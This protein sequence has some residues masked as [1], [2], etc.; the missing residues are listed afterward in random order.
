MQNKANSLEDY[1]HQ[2]PKERQIVIKKIR[3]NNIFNC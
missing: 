3:R 2:A 1:I